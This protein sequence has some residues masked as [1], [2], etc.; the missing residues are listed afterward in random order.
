M[1]GPVEIR[2]GQ[3]I[4]WLHIGILAGRGTAAISAPEPAPG[5]QALRTPLQIDRVAA[6]ARRTVL[7]GE[8][9]VIPQAGAR[10]S[11]RWCAR[12][13]LSNAANSDATVNKFAIRNARI[14]S[15]D[16]AAHRECRFSL[17]RGIG[18]FA[19]EREMKF[20]HGLALVCAGALAFAAAG[21]ALASG[22]GGGGGGAAGGGG[23]GA[24]GGGGGG[25]APGPGPIGNPPST[26]PLVMIGTGAT[27]Q[28]K[29]GQTLQFAVEVQD[30]PNQPTLEMTTAPAGMSTEQFFITRPNLAKGT[31]WE[32]REFVLYTPNQAG[33][34]EALF[35]GTDPVTGAIVT[36]TWMLVVTP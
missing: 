12:R 17:N 19:K 6:A 25:A 7:H 35:T 20:R 24:G 10:D 18:F 34:F 16:Q 15:P 26:E 5:Y 1:S 33:T 29:L 9:D 8:T 30:G 23:G 22:P 14:E 21:S 4:P 2:T 28:I 36:G 13:I 27:V 3:N 32:V 31:P 11:A